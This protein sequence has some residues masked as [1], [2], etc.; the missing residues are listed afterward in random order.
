M[1]VSG[2]PLPKLFSPISTKPLAKN[3]NFLH[4]EYNP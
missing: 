3:E 1:T 4:G 2:V